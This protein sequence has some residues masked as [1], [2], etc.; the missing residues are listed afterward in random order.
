MVILYIEMHHDCPLVAAFKNLASSML[1]DGRWVISSVSII[2][3]HK[4]KKFDVINW[5]KCPQDLATVAPSPD[6]YYTDSGS[7][8]TRWQ[9]PYPGC[10]GFISE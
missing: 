10:F 9:R 4:M 8:C 1:M 5:V 7:K 6:R 2:S 3:F